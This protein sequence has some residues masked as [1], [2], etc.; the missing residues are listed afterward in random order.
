MSQSHRMLRD[1]MMS[2]RWRFLV[3]IFWI[4]TLKM[5]AARSSEMLGIPPKHY[6]ASQP[7][8]LDSCRMLFSIEQLW[9]SIRVW[10][11]PDICWQLTFLCSDTGLFSRLWTKQICRAMLSKSNCEIHPRLAWWQNSI[12]THTYI[13]PCHFITRG[14]NAWP[15]HMCPFCLV[16]LVTPWCELDMTQKFEGFDVWN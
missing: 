1:L 2:R 3:H 5:E 9:Y 13:L 14:T 12:Y 16:F 6:T 15:V 7:K 10:R 8:D 4:L 11:W